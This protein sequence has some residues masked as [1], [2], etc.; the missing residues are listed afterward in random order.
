VLNRYTRRKSVNEEAVLYLTLHI[1]QTDARKTFGVKYVVLDHHQCTPKDFH[2]TLI[3]FRLLSL[4]S[5]VFPKTSAT[6]WALSFRPFL[7]AYGLHFIVKL[8][9]FFAFRS[10]VAFNLTI[11]IFSARIIDLSIIC[12]CLFINFRYWSIGTTANNTFINLVQCSSLTHILENFK[13]IRFFESINRPFTSDLNLELFLL[14]KM[15][16]RLHLLSRNENFRNFKTEQATL[17][18]IHTVCFPWFPTIFGNF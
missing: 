9:R 16:N 8:A 10:W 18:P 4:R 6:N 17:T 12:F 14:F 11:V 15:M 3:F 13:H 7:L 1:D 2:F 5:V